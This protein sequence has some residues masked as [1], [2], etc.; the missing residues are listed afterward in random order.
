MLWQ[1]SNSEKNSTLF[2]CGAYRAEPRSRLLLALTIRRK[3]VTRSEIRFNGR[4]ISA[5]PVD[6]VRKEDLGRIV[7]ILE[8]WL[9][10]CA[11]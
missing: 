11:H 10:C 1:F 4:Y 8:S 7:P 6:A 2:G 9:C 3:P 5:L